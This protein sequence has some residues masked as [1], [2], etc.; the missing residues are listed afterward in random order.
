VR[1]MS[2]NV[3]PRACTTPSFIEELGARTLSGET[4]LFCGAGIS[5]HSGLPLAA[6]FVRSVAEHLTLD[7]V[8]AQLIAN[9]ALPFE[10]CFQ[11]IRMNS[12]VTPLYE[13]FS[14]GTPSLTHVLLAHL[15]ASRMVP[16]VYTTHFDC[17]LERAFER[18]GLRRG[19]DFEV[20]QREDHFERVT[21]KEGRAKLWRKGQLAFVP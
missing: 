1:P 13:I 21:A 7:P 2:E 9:S 20:Y 8:N 18:N 10:T 16:N 15:V 14:H 3:S 5:F 4:A 17:L 11:S 19:A 12:D 6:V